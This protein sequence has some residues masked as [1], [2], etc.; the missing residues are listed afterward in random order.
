MVTRA[1]LAV[2]ALSFLLFSATSFADTKPDAQAL[3]QVQAE[4]KRGNYQ[5]ISP[6]T[7]K[8]QFVKEPGS[9]LLVDTRQ[10]WEYQGEH[11]KGAVS[12]PV[13]PTWWTQYSPWVRGEMKKLL[14]P[15]KKRQ[16]V[17]Y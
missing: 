2:L 14:G 10:G 7:I 3:A 15:D 8:D 11:I 6:E 5:L 16:V 4:A 12:L 13:T 1:K 17:F 9:L